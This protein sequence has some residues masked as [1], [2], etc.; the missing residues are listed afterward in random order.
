M[1]EYFEREDRA[2]VK[3]VLSHEILVV[4]DEFTI[5]SG[6]IG[7]QAENQKHSHYRERMF[8]QP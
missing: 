7:Q 3:W 5:E 6:S 2:F 8:K 1:T 4:P